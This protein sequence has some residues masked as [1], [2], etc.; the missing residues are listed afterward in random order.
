LP[1]GFRGGNFRAWLFEIARHVLIDHARKR[2]PEPLDDAEHRRDD[3]AAAPDAGLIE[4]ERS[5]ALRRCLERLSSEAVA[6]VR[7]RL[8]GADDREACRRLDLTPERAYTLFHRAKEQL[9]ACLERVL[10]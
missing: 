10:A 8:G 6:L 5:E 9:Q 7:A 2:R 4:R 3:R 1:G